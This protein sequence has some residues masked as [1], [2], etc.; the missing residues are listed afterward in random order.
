MGSSVIF[1]N[2]GLV[3]GGTSEGALC[4]W[5]GV[6]YTELYGFL[7]RPRT[8][9]PHGPGDSSKNLV[10]MLKASHASLPD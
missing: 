6:Y 8:K 3:T 1:E 7:S 9:L 2:N 10:V 5:Q 4:H